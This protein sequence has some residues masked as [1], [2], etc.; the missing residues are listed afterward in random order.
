MGDSLFL[1]NININFNENP[2]ITEEKDFYSSDY[3]VV[4]TEEKNIK[5]IAGIYELTKKISFKNIVINENSTKYYNAI[6]KKWENIPSEKFKN[7]YMKYSQ[8]YR[9]KEE[10]L[11]S[12]KTINFNNKY[13]KN[14]FDENDRYDMRIDSESAIGLKESEVVKMHVD[15]F[16]AIT[17][18]YTLKSINEPFKPKIILLTSNESINNSTVNT[19]NF[20]NL[21]IFG[22]E[23][24]FFY[25]Y[26][27]SENYIKFENDVINLR[28]EDKYFPLDMNNEY[29]QKLLQF[30]KA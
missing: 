11:N 24:D 26:I 13:I 9:K 1:K 12:L 25:N 29:L 14:S 4:I 22:T 30:W 20:P 19:I 23:R 21:K 18:K 17:R 27:T 2:N 16:N 5:N 3:N 8:F 28:I 10:L 15:L 6:S 7:F